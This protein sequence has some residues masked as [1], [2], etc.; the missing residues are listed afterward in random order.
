[1]IVMAYINACISYVIKPTLGV[2]LL[3]DIK[4]QGF[5]KSL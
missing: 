5:Y 4:D 3:E 2:L 1:M